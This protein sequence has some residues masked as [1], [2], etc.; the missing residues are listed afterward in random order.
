MG[1]RPPVTLTRHAVDRASIR[2]LDKFMGRKRQR[3][4][5]FSWLVREAQRAYQTQNPLECAERRAYGGYIWVFRGYDLI[6]MWGVKEKPDAV[7][8]QGEG[9]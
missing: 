4:G 5:F 8:A 3:L 1:Y 6:T 7:P 2:M 9:R